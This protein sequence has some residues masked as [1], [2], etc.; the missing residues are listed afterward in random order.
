[1]IYEL[2]EERKKY[3]RNL[4]FIISGEVLA[5]FSL[6]LL[7]FNLR[8]VVLGQVNYIICTILFFFFWAV[9]VIASYAKD[10][11]WGGYFLQRVE[12]GPDR[13]ILY[14][15]GRKEE[16]PYSTI[17]TI[18]IRRSQ[19]GSKIK[20]IT[21]FLMK[22][23]NFDH[24]KSIIK[25]KK[26]HRLD[27]FEKMNEIEATLKGTIN[28]PEIFKDGPFGEN[29]L[30]KLKFRG[31][32]L[33]L[34]VIPIFLIVLLAGVGFMKALPALALLVLG[35]ACLR[36]RKKYPNLLRFGKTILLATAIVS[37]GL[38]ILNW[39]QIVAP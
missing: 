32:V 8:Q 38:I 14:Y 26:L 28:D 7:A 9:T 37:V 18:F 6:I 39:P 30:V 11:K 10:S 2:K 33:L 24:V 25:L 27:G 35:V 21:V 22:L 13:M 31:Y 20:L 34:L 17:K 36:F 29:P 15:G 23:E 12:M 1:L 16:V 4:R 19:D 5:Y 3:F